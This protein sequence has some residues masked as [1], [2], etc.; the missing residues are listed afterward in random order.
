MSLIFLKIEYNLTIFVVFFGHLS[1]YM[2]HMYYKVESFNI[3]FS[4]ILSISLSFYVS[5][6]D[7]RF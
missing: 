6:I 4:S 7:I 2:V 3:R 5:M 1:T